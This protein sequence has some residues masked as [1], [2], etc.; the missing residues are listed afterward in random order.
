MDQIKRLVIL[1]SMALSVSAVAF[2][3]A[4]QDAEREAAIRKCL[5]ETAANTPQGADQQVRISYYSAC[6]ARAGQRP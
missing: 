1:S 2:P 3:A 6:M 4:A 5:A